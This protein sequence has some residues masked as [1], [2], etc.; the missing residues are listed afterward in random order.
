V[1]QHD[2]ALTRKEYLIEP[3]SVSVGRMVGD[4]WKEEDSAVNPYLL[5]M[6]HSVYPLD[7]AESWANE[8]H[9]LLESKRNE[10]DL[11]QLCLTDE[12]E[13]PQLVFQNWRKV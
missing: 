13:M 1:S 8:G 9:T 12:E 6:Y 10:K 7:D 3:A 11:E 5:L 2:A 4:T